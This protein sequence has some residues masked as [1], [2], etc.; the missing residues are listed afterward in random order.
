MVAI[1]NF[2]AKI[3]GQAKQAIQSSKHIW[4]FEILLHSKVNLK[5]RIPTEF[6]VD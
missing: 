5:E 3:S 4:G 6:T 1:T 2:S